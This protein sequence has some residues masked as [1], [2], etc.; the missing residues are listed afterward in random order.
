MRKGDDLDPIN[1]ETLEVLEMLAPCRL[2]G[3]GAI[4]GTVDN[5]PAKDCWG[6]ILSNAPCC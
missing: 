4:P 6:R 3:I 5:T 2:I 1:A